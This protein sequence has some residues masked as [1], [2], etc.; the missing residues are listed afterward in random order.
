MIRATPTGVATWPGT[1]ATM[2][3]A[4]AAGVRHAAVEAAARVLEAEEQATRRR[5]RAVEDRLIPRLHEALVAVQLTLDE[6]EHED[7]VRLRWAARRRVGVDPPAAG[8]GEAAGRP[9]R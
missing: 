3:A 7:G 6:E 4:L 9:G 8:T 1:S 2:P 5:L